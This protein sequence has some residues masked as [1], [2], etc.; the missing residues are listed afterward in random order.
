MKENEK[1]FVEF[2]EHNDISSLEND[3]KEK[4][5]EAEKFAWI[6]AG[7]RLRLFKHIDEVMENALDTGNYDSVVEACKHCE[8]IIDIVEKIDNKYEMEENDNA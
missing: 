8:L 4:V 2:D 7:I 3:E 5:M 1:D 6:W